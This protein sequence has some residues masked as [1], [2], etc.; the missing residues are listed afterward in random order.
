MPLTTKTSEMIRI[1]R[2][3]LRELLGIEKPPLFALVER[4][5]RAMAQ[6]RVGHLDLVAEIESLVRASTLLFSSLET[7]LPELA[8]QTASAA[9]KNVLNASWRHWRLR[10]QDLPR[11]VQ[12]S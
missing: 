10:S 1:V 7:A 12:Q 8:F 6:Y 11:L 5:A 9:A 4:H 3:N 2:Q